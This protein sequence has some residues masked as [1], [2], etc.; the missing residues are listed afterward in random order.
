MRVPAAR[1]FG[2]VFKFDNLLVFY[3]VKYQYFEYQNLC[4]SVLS[5][6]SAFGIFSKSI[7]FTSAQREILN[8]K[9]V[10]F[11]FLFYFFHLV[12]N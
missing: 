6:R 3:K 10:P 12:R 9:F 4:E 1:F 7:C 2:V 5:I 11:S 8:P